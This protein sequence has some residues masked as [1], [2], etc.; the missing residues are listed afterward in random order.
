MKC[1]NCNHKVAIPFKCNFCPLHICNKCINLETHSCIGKD[2]KIARDKQIL[3]KN[4]E[5][6]VRKQS[7]ILLD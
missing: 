6:K 2:D 5:F 4:L 7:T 1:E 3:H